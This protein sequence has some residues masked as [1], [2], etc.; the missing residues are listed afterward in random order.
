MAGTVERSEPRP[1]N[2]PRE[3]LC[4]LV[5]RDGVHGAVHDQRGRGDIG[6]AL[7]ECRRLAHRTQLIAK[8]TALYRVLRSHSYLLLDEFGMRTL[9][10]RRVEHGARHAICL[11][12]RASAAPQQRIANRGIRRDGVAP[13]RL[14]GGQDQTPDKLGVIDGQLLRDDPAH[15]CTENVNGAF[16]RAGDDGS[17]VGSQSRHDERQRSAL[18]A[19]DAAGIER[20]H[21]VLPTQRG[22]KRIEDAPRRAQS[23]DEQHWR[24]VTACDGSEHR[25]VRSVDSRGL[26]D[27][28]TG[29]CAI[30]RRVPRFFVD[31]G[32]VDGDVVHI[33][34]ESAAHLARSLRARAGERIVV[35]EA[36]TVEHGVV[37]TDVGATQVSGQIEWSRPATGESRLRIHLLQAVPARGFDDTIEALAIAGADTIHPVITERGV[38]RLDDGASRTK[39]ARWEAIAREAAQLAGRG[40]APRIAPAMPLAAALAALPSPCPILACVA[41]ERAIAIETV[42]VGDTPSVACVIGPEGGLGPRDLVELDA[43]DA[44]KVHLGP[45]IVPSRMA[46]FLAVSLL[47]ARDGDLDRPPADAPHTADTVGR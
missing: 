13:R 18:G 8:E 16:G 36:G 42:A 6:K 28:W 30:M 15:R 46:G 40:R 33:G 38:V 27:H 35:V 1:G 12:G 19:A 26:L 22:R 7:P 47:L 17:G 10:L 5:R 31:A 23:R 29:V 45:R 37:L 4:V 21:V 24:T 34:G 39:A 25:A 11:L 3:K 20:D 32:A 14:C 43:R 9:K 44:T 41:E 2:T